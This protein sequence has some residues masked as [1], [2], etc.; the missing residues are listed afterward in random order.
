MLPS[1]LAKLFVN[2]FANMIVNVLALDNLYGRHCPPS[3]RPSVRPSSSSTYCQ[4]AMFVAGLAALE[5]LKIDSPEKVSRCK[6]FAGL[7]LGE[8]TALAAAGVFDFETGLQL[9]KARAEGMAREASNSGAP[10]VMASIAGVCKIDLESMC[11]TCAGA[12]TIQSYLS[13]PMAPPLV[14]W[15]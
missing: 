9:V 7:S 6:A 8:Y 4:P 15:D 2:M 3:V 12:D 13:N 11:K 10:Q 5:K 1:I 14:W